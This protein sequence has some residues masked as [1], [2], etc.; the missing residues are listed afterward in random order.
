MQRF[1]WKTSL[2]S[3]TI[4][5]QMANEVSMSFLDKLIDELS[6]DEKILLLDDASKIGREELTSIMISFL[7]DDLKMYASSAYDYVCTCD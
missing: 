5:G 2:F 6:V 3:A 1:D 7:P 4:A